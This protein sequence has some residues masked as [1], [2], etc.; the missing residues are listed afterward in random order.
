MSSISESHTV[1]GRGG[2]GGGKGGGQEPVG[3]SPV[4]APNSLQS[5]SIARFLDLWCE[6]PIEGLVNE[7]QSIFFDDTPLKNADGS[8][9]FTGVAWDTRYGFPFGTQKYMAGFPSSRSTV[10]VGGGNGI[11]IKKG[12]G[13]TPGATHTINNPMANAA[14]VKITTPALYIQNNV[15]GDVNNYTSNFRIFVTAHG[16]TPVETHYVGFHG[17]C[18]STYQRDYRV[19]L[20]AGGAPWLITFFRENED[21]TANYIQ[22]ALYLTSVTEVVDG[23]LAHPNT[24]YCGVQIDTAQFSGKAPARSYDVKGLLIKIPSNYDPITRKYTGDWNGTFTTAWSDNPAWC[25]YDLLTNTRYGLGLDLAAVNPWK[26]DLYTIGQY[27]D[28]VDE[29]GTYVGVDDGAGGKEPRYTCNMLLNSRQEAYAVINTMAS[30]FRGMPFWSS[31]AVRATADMP[32]APVALFTNANVLGGEFKYEGTSLKARHT[33]AKVVW[34][35]PADAYRP[36][37]EWVDDPEGV[38]LY[39]VRQIDIVAYGCTSRGQAIRTGKWVLDTER[40][41]TETVHFRSG[42]ELADKFPG[43]I[44]SI[45][46]ENYAQQIFGGRI[47]S[48]THT[49][50]TVDQPY[51]VLAAFSYTL[52]I[53]MP[54]GTLQKRTLTNV[55]GETATFTWSTPLH[56]EPLAGAVWVITSTSLQARQFLLV[57]NIEVGPATFEAMGVFHD[58]AKFDRVEKGIVVSPPPY[59]VTP[60]GPIVPPTGPT[61]KMRLYQVGSAVRAAV[62]LS[63]EKSDDGRVYAYEVQVK[64]PQDLDY[65][66]IGTT[67]MT[68]IEYQDSQEG[69]YVFRVRAKALNG[70]TSAWMEAKPVTLTTAVPPSD[71]TG[72][73]PVF[74]PDGVAI[75]W[76]AVED[77]NVDYYEVR[78]GA[79]WGTSTRVGT[80]R[81]LRY[82]E[83]GVAAGTHTYWV[84]AVTKPQG[85]YSPTPS[86]INVV[87]A[88]PPTPTV[89]VALDADLY[90]LTWTGGV[91]AHG[92]QVEEYEVR[93]GADWSSA[94]FVTF[95]KGTTFTAPVRWGGSRRFWVAAKDKAGNYS[96]P[97]SADLNVSAATSV[98]NLTAQV[99]DNNVLLRWGQATSA[100][101][102]D[103]YVVKKGATWASGTLIGD[104]SGTF[105]SVFESAS[106]TYT[107]WVA[108]VDSG[109]NEGVPM[110]VTAVVSQPPDY[111]LR[112]EDFADLGAGRTGHVYSRITAGDMYAGTTALCPVTAGKT[113]RFQI[114]AKAWTEP[115]PVRLHLRDGAN[116]EYATFDFTP[117]SSWQLY[118][119]Q[120]TFPSG[121]VPDIVVYVN[122]IG[123]S[124]AVGASLLLADAEIVQVG[125]LTNLLP[126]DFGGSGWYYSGAGTGI[127]NA[128]PGPFDGV[129]TN[130]TV[131]AGVLYGPA[132]TGETWATHFTDQ[133]WDQPSDQIAAGYLDWLDPGPSTASYVEVF[134]YDSIVQGTLVTIAPNK[135]DFSGA[136]ALSITLESSLDGVAWTMVGTGAQQ[137]VSNFRYLRVTLNLTSAGAVCAINAVSVKLASKTKTDAGMALAVAGDAGGTT[138]TFNTPFASVSSI[139][140]TP[141]GT[142]ARYAIYDFAGTPYPTSFKVLLFDAAGNR[143][144]GQVS[145][146]ARGY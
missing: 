93:T 121:A 4:E 103:R 114:W 35:D 140:V 51:A 124:G 44:V 31:G 79:S 75:K 91:A 67:S 30:I 130:M 10:A 70:K 29:T 84:A 48:A 98:T 78:R 134:D 72:L 143:L 64:G 49:S 36:A 97:A 96:T 76:D 82:T 92:F 45:A 87:V 115:G 113:F 47:I 24:A 46:D 17:K 38:S 22:D 101:P 8:F 131:Q 100:L 11:E 40:T 109:G 6:G 59:N 41:A 71:V 14:I 42:L 81:E 108:A 99:I 61:S 18:T 117:T 3:R 116:T 21:H 12:N 127:Q 39:G 62:L 120:A 54:D 33:T 137:Y 111:L 55:A 34:N 136:V 74:D 16:G 68:S 144:T 1:F 43:D 104:K 5:R 26:W 95:V 2:S 141:V 112:T 85:I 65:Q 69:V 145:W 52:H 86:G 32:K 129:L 63:W 90:K 80:P 66:T 19:A 94:T 126:F 102:I 73:Q 57:S 128:V 132:D 83:K 20:P 139:Q 133:G 50:V 110:S 105:T 56:E 15:T 135:T 60:T 106:G 142:A 119:V 58:P 37:V 27:C 53:T 146:T 138:V 107:Y 23:K 25:F 122:P 123:D 28:A 118:K 9:N 88:A 7:D 125:S 89:Q 13:L 77:L